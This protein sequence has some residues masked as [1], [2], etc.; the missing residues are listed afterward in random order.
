MTMSRPLPSDTFTLSGGSFGYYGFHDINPSAQLGGNGIRLL[1]SVA[2]PPTSPVAGTTY[3][4][5]T[6]MSAVTYYS[7]YTAQAG[8]T[9]EDVIDGIIADV[10]GGSDNSSTKN[11]L[12]Y[13]KVD[14]PPVSNFTGQKGIQV[15]GQARFNYNHQFYTSAS[16]MTLN[17]TGWLGSSTNPFPPLVSAAG[18]DILDNYYDANDNIAFQFNIVQMAE[19]DRPMYVDDTTG[20]PSGFVTVF[21]FNS[22]AAD[23]A[24]TV[25][26]Y[27]G[28]TPKIKKI[29]FENISSPG[30]GYDD[31][32]I[33]SEDLL[34]YTTQY[35]LYLAT[36]LSSVNGSAYRALPFRENDN[37]IATL[38]FSSSDLGFGT[39]GSK[40]IISH[41]II[42]KG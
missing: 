37:Y 12:T 9:Q 15:T 32:V 30:A 7:S 18:A 13:K 20:W 38:E 3:A 42:S 31:I 29:T 28:T 21:L 41:N 14:A 17:P 23:A 5:T 33:T 11:I 22:K 19:A 24:A 27:G 16:N 26:K 8:D 6:Y 34:P 25:A 10:S 35:G 40:E 2:V 1:N 36:G 4:L 39:G